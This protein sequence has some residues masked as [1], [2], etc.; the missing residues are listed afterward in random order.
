MVEPSAHDLAGD[1]EAGP[2]E[3]RHLLAFVVLPA[4]AHPQ[5][6]RLARPVDEVHEGG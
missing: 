2:G 4:H 1:L 3:G 6:V 5:P